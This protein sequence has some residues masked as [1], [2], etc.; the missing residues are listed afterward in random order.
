VFGWLKSG[1]KPTSPRAPTL[2]FAES[3]DISEK[4]S[5]I[6]A[7]GDVHGCSDLLEKL[8][9]EID[10]SRLSDKGTAA[11]VFLGDLIDRG[12]N[13]STTLEIVA[14]LASQSQTARLVFVLKGNHE[15][16]FL[17][18]LE[19]P[20]KNAGFWLR[21][22]GTE[23]LRSYGINI[24]SDVVSLKEARALHRQTT[25]AIPPRHIALVQSARALLH[26][27]SHVFCHASIDTDAPLNQQFEQT[28]LWSRRYPPDEADYNGPQIVHGH[29]PH[30]FPIAASHHINVDTGAYATGVLTAV[31]LEASQQKFISV[32][33]DRKEARFL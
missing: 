33:I 7:I 21:N 18:F 17:D 13:S 6:Y 28:L 23:T 29:E 8:L 22:G 24:R 32:S 15:Q 10:A 27:K 26:T 25:A 1:F 19:N 16:M 5:V 4:A 12:T 9:Q 30:K 11:I 14:S 2:N 31:R 3:L 20:E